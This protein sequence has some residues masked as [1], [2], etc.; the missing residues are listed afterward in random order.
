MIFALWQ[1]SGTKPAVPLRSAFRHIDNFSMW[2][3]V[4]GRS[5]H[6]LRRDTGIRVGKVL[7]YSKNKKWSGGFPGGSVVQNLPA[8][9]GDMGSI[10]GLG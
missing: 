3:Q 8:N 2:R 6:R 10:P 4:L 1:W 7:Y 5:V 9:S